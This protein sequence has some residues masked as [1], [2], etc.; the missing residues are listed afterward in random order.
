M[1]E[2]FERFSYGVFL[3]CMSLRLMSLEACP[4]LFRNGLVLFSRS[5]YCAVVFVVGVV[6]GPWV[7][8]SGGREKGR[9][10]MSWLPGYAR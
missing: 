7:L 5:I 2:L 6:C 3:G 9:V 10:D 8:E 1:I 4:A